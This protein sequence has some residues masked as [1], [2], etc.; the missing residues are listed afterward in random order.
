MYVATLNVW[1]GLVTQ[2]MISQM[3]IKAAELNGDLAEEL[4]KMRTVNRNNH[5]VSNDENASLELQGMQTTKRYWVS[6][7]AANQWIEWIKANFEST[8]VSIEIV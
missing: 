3:S 2:D 1:S 4:D 5:M 7:D 8:L 6:E